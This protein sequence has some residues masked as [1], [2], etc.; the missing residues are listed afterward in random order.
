[1]LHDYEISYER[2]RQKYSNYH[3]LI[4]DRS[5]KLRK[6][7][8]LFAQNGELLRFMDDDVIIDLIGK[9]YDLLKKTPIAER[10]NTVIHEGFHSSVIEGA[11]TTVADTV[12]MIRD[13]EKPK[14]KSE[15]MVLNNVILIN[16]YYDNL[17]IFDEQSILDAW[18][19]LITGVCENEDIKGIKYRI[20]P[21]NIVDGIGKVIYIAPSHELIQEHMNNFFAFCKDFDHDPLI[22][23]IL[24]HYY[25]VYIH[26]FCDGNG[27]LS[28]FLL[29][30]WLIQNEKTNKFKYISLSVAV[31]DSRSQYYKSL[32]YSENILNDITYFIRY[33]LRIMEAQLIKSCE[34][35]GV[36]VELNGRQK[37]IMIR[38]KVDGITIKKYAEI[39]KVDEITAKEELDQLVKLGD[40]KVINEKYCKVMN[41]F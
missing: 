18:K 1:M 6:L 4:Q 5:V 10:V 35:F 3:S 34:S 8:G 21:V 23:A 40:F 25:I 17:F 11:R 16:K 37:S 9:I 26:P 27:R 39:Y 22:K 30:Q 7:T 28:R 13:K 41:Y 38:S 33:Y 19:I 15:Q 32:E 2:L 14:N 24:I 29:H 36:D 12:R 31:N 20:G